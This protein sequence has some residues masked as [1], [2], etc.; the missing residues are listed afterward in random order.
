MLPG[1][2]SDNGNVRT[3][4]NVLV[5]L[6]NNLKSTSVLV[7]D[8]PGPAGALDTSKLGIDVA[9]Q[10]VEVAVVLRNGLAERRVSR[11]GLT[12]TLG[13]GGQVLPEETVVNVTTT[14]ELDDIG[15]LNLGLDIT[16]GLGLLDLLNGG[17]V[18]VDISLV[19]LGVVDLVDLAGDEGLESTKVVIEVGESGLATGKDRGGG[20]SGLERAG[21]SVTGN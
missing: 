16:D 15:E 10:V 13:L 19:V 8:N 7:L 4:D 6:G 17:V 3:V 12:T 1:I 18:G 21:K 20:E 9:N 5:G 14:V 2:N 11:G